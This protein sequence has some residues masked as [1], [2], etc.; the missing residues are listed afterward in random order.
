MGLM[1]RIMEDIW[2][3][4]NIYA[5]IIRKEI[6]DSKYGI[7]WP[8]FSSSYAQPQAYPQYNDRYNS[9]GPVTTTQVTIPTELAGKL[10]KKKLF[11]LKI[12]IFFKALLSVQKVR[13]SLKFDKNQVHQLKLIRNL[14]PVL[15]ID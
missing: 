15:M 2:I 10:L 1:S 4:N 6:N 9:V 3:I 7:V 13:K 12:R 11:K 5:E 14:C 8:F